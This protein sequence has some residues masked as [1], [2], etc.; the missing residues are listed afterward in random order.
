MMKNSMIISI[1]GLPNSGKSTLI[2]A[3]AKKKVAITDDIPNTTRDYISINIEVEDLIL[4]LIDLP[5]YIDSPDEYLK[6][7]QKNINSNLDKSDLILLV[8]DSKNPNQLDMDKLIKKLRLYSEKVWLLIN[9]VD[10]FDEI[11]LDDV[12]YNY[13]FS[14]EFYIS[15]YHKKGINTLFDSIKEHSKKIVNNNS[16]VKNQG[17]KLSIIGRPNV[18]KS[19]VF[20]S[21]LDYER[22]GVSNIPGTTLD[23]ISEF[24]TLEET[25][26]EISDTAGIP[27]KKQK[28]GIDRV[29]SLMSLK[30]IPISSVTL[31][32]VDSMDGLKVEDI[33]LIYE[34]IENNVTPIV[35]LNKWDLLTNEEKVVIEKDIKHE[36]HSNNWV[37]IV[38]TSTV[39]KRGI[40]LLEK[41]I[42]KVYSSM[43][44]R[45]K[46][47]EVNK[48]IRSLW[49]SSPPHP[50][51]GTRAK[52]KY[53]NQYSTHPPSF[54]FQLKG[55]VPKN[56]RRFLV[57]QLRREYNFGS[58]AIKVKF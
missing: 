41:T 14:K 54:S 55:N 48:F 19:S 42:K 9:K 53:V 58:T 12:I 56:Y 20:N 52:I 1:V 21:L 16:I 3:L 51:R 28:R 34:C 32:V 26:F 7:F 46:T 6:I 10:N 25:V 40:D 49:I 44:Q 8:L 43:G 15:G 31:I 50:Y 37:S 24:V 23:I 4:E 18:G 29:G 27:R 13:Q 2:N 22:S 35:V 5:G 39:N 38:R 30:Q 47:S 11:Y 57:T 45:V 33:K 36:L 17:S